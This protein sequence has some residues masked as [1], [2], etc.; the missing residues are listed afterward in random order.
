MRLQPHLCRYW[1]NPKKDCELQF[2]LQVNQV[3]QLYQSANKLLE[4]NI[5]VVSVDEMT[6]IQA[7]ERVEKRKLVKPNQVE[8]QEYEYIR[9]GTQSLMGNWH[10]AKGKIIAPTIKSTRT[11][12]DFV[13]HIN[14]T[15]DTEPQ[16][17]WIF[18]VDQLNTHLS[19]SLV[20]MV[21]RR[22]EIDIDLGEK[23]SSGI[24]KSMSSR[25]EFL[26]NQEHRIRFVYVPKH[27]SWL[28]QIECWFSILVRRLI[29]RTSFISTEDL[30]E[31]ILNFIDYF[32]QYFSKPF[33]WKFTGY[34]T[35]A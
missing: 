25:G 32:N 3:C 10:V 29:K 21:A 22:C 7:L 35:D 6:G 19:E 11:E 18:I 15:I 20:K 26:S 30:K 28:N 5:H 31:K 34:E 16:S 9:H 33:N 12:L 24:L 4:E 1:L 8:K 17:G 23:G 27:T 13:E 14:K 2:K